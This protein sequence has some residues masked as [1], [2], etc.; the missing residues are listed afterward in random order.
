MDFFC[1]VLLYSMTSLHTAL[2]RSRKPSNHKTATQINVI[3]HPTTV[4][5]W[6]KRSELAEY[7]A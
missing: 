4:Q 3:Q 2:F 1:I 6:L 7:V 5:K